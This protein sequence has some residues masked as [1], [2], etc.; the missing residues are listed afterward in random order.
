VNITSWD[1]IKD[2]F[3]NAAIIL[4]NGASISFDDKFDYPSLFKK[5]ADAQLITPETQEIFGQFSVTDFE[6]VLL[7]LWRASQ[8]NKVLK[9]ETN[10]VD[11]AYDN[12]RSALINVVHHIHGSF[13]EWKTN[14]VFINHLINAAAFLKGFHTVISLNYDCLIYWV[15][16]KGKDQFGNWFK[17]TFTDHGESCVDWNKLREPYKADGAS[18]VLYPHG[19]LCLAIDRA[20]ITRKLSCKNSQTSLIDFI[21]K[22]WQ[23]GNIAP[24]FVCEGESSHKL[25]RI[26]SNPYL[27]R[28]YNELHKLNGYGKQIVIYG[29]DIGDQDTHILEAIKHNK[30]EKIAIS[31]HNSNKNYYD[32]VKKLL[33]THLHLTNQQILF[34]HANSVNCWI[35]Q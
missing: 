23:S 22:Q 6:Q 35:Y 12:V 34:F 10:A 21:E 2:Q 14:P 29:W 1:E 24:L 5:T 8:I 17:D 11:I 7:Q 25:A 13:E 26:K 19:N 3:N 15:I 28:V 4:G 33:S 9:V 27:A 32:R 16:L 18:L 31:I 30:I 20:S